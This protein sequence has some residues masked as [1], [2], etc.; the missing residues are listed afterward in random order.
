MTKRA[1]PTISHATDAW[2]VY[3]NN[4]QKLVLGQVE[5]GIGVNAVAVTITKS[6]TFDTDKSAFADTRTINSV[7][8]GCGALNEYYI[9]A[10]QTICLEKYLLYKQ[11]STVLLMSL[12]PANRHYAAILEWLKETQ[13]R[14]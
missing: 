2:R 14:S 9:S 3:Q 11:Q 10:I 12:D 1:N 7:I 6:S 4:A 5:H 8:F 13:Y